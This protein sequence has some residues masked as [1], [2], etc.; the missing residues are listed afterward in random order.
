MYMHMYIGNEKCIIFNWIHVSLKLILFITN[1]SNKFSL[2]IC[3]FQQKKREMRFADLPLKSAKSA[4]E[5]QLIVPS[6]LILK[7][8]FSVSKF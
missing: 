2:L 5:K 8:K 3:R 4:C 1:V 6:V 7:L